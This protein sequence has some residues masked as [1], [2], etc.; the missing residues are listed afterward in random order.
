MSLSR[1]H[2]AQ[3]AAGSYE[4]NQ[5]ALEIAQGIHPNWTVDEE[6][7]NR[8]MKTYHRPDTKE[9]VVS[10]RGTKATEGADLAADGLYFFGLG[11]HSSRY[12]N[13]KTTTKKVMERYCTS[14]DCSNLSTA[15]HS[16][17]GSI[18]SDISKDLDITT[19]NFGKGRQLL[20]RSGKKEKN[21]RNVFDPLSG[22]GM[23]VVNLTG[24]L[25]KPRSVNPHS[26]KNF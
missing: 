10:Y 3:L 4:S 6:F 23:G 7:S 18:G 1:S 25:V 21:Y 22:S 13:A 24:K 8:H 2:Q 5:R 14:G 11:R 17:G 15:S 26:L 19:T 9:T 12:K 20:P 16:L